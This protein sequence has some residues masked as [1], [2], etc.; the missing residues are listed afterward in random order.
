M[1]STF[2]GP[3]FM[4]VMYVSRIQAGLW[5]ASVLVPKYSFFGLPEQAPDQPLALCSLGRREGEDL[6]VSH[7]TQKEPMVTSEPGGKLGACD[8]LWV[9][10]S[11]PSP[12]KAR[13]RKRGFLE[14]S[15]CV[16]SIR[17]SVD[18]S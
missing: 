18:E 9:L 12:P 3:R 11:P 5:I 13:V 15:C 8:S 6:Q 14:G 17:R 4:C 10:G 16:S 2:P 1:L 7:T